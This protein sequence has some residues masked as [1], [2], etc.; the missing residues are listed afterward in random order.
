[1]LSSYQPSIS[2]CSPLSLSSVL[3]LDLSDHVSSKQKGNRNINWAGSL[4]PVIPAF[5]RLKQGHEFI[6]N[7]AYTVKLCLGSHRAGIEKETKE[8]KEGFKQKSVICSCR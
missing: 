6:A 3:R 4:M 7:T 8:K 1:M 5:G 2:Q